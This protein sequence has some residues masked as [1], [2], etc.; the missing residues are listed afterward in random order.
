MAN[1]MGIQEVLVGSVP[2]SEATDRLTR[3]AWWRRDPA[4]GGTLVS[5][6]LKPPDPNLQTRDSNIGGL[7]G[8]Q[9]RLRD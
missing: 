2:R 5:V 3:A 7:N 4:V 9:C 8:F 1:E 6:S